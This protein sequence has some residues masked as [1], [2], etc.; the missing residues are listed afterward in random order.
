[1][2]RKLVR[3]SKRK[4]AITHSIF[5]LNTMVSF[6]KS[7]PSTEPDMLPESD[8]CFKPGYFVLL[9]TVM[10]VASATNI[11]IIPA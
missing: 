1:M 5:F 7:I 6:S 4:I 2:K 11:L 10:S 9:M 8:C 3:L